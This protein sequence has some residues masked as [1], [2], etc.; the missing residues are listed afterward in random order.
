[1]SQMKARGD[2]EWDRTQRVSQNGTFNANPITAAVAI[3]TLDAVADGSVQRTADERTARL[4]AGIDDAMRSIGV[5]GSCYGDSSIF[6]VS[7]EGMG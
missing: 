3:A 1:M 5:P 6:H 2:A 7:F 4:R